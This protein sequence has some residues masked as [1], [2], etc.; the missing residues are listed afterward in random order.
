M[1][2]KSKKVDTG[3]VTD[4][5]AEAK[6]MRKMSSISAKQRVDELRKQFNLEL[7]KILEEE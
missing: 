4:F 3:P 1:K 7:L 6:R 5:E 2:N